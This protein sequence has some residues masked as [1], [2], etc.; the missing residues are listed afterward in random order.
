[1]LFFKVIFL[2]CSFS[3][4][5]IRAIL[6]FCEVDVLN[7]IYHTFLLPTFCISVSSWK[8][9]NLTVKNVLKNTSFPIFKTVLMSHHGV[10]Q[11]K[12]VTVLNFSLSAFCSL[13]LD[14]WF[15]FFFQRQKQSGRQTKK[16]TIL[17]YS[18]TY[19]IQEK[20]IV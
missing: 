11:I 14:R 7:E 19:A 5:F 20:L 9:V 8:S 13:G 2:F 15:W 1:M 3:S 12:L 17:Y 16:K 6:F 4:T 18:F 10:Q